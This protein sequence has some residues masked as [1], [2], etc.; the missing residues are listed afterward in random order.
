VTAAALQFGV[1]RH[2]AWGPAVGHTAAESHT[3]PAT[4]VSV[5]VALGSADGGTRR[6]AEDLL[7]RAYWGPVVAVA[8][9]KWHLDVADAED[10][11]QDF[12]AQALAK[13]WFV[14]FDP[15]KARFRTF[16]RVCLDRFAANA[17]QSAGRLR[18]GGD[19]V[20]ESLDDS[21]SI[22]SDDGAIDD[23]FRQEWIRSVFAMSLEALRE[24]GRTTGK[25]EH[26]AIFEAYDVHD[27]PDDR[28]PSY[29]DLA[30]TFGLPETTVTNHL[31]WAR[32]AFRAHVLATLQSLAGSDTEFRTD[33]QELL[34]TRVA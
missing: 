21:L 2:A 15:S 13:Q 24:E 18:R 8:Q 12:F 27:H 11:A 7:A 16:L 28:R 32:S 1:R 31:A 34:G 30:T 20:I 22:P 9:I 19:L 6:A 17:F 33:A 14:K 29:R 26:V 25:R 10:L 3:F 23:R 4:R 5:I